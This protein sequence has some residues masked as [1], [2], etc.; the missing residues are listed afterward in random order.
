MS[1]DRPKS[2][3]P[4]SPDYSQ[5]SACLA[6]IP[7]HRF[8]KLLVVGPSSGGVRPET[9]AD[10][11]NRRRARGRLG[12][13]RRPGCR[14]TWRQLVGSA[15]LPSRHGRRRLLRGHRGAVGHFTMTPTGSTRRSPCPW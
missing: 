10:G 8:R 2:T 4:S 11:T 5:V 9:G 3:G 15:R 7:R 12:R 6:A 14:G 13:W 1:R